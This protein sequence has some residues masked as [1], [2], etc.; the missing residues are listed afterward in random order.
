MKPIVGA[1]LLLGI[2]GF[3]HADGPV[4]L[5]P[6]ARAMLDPIRNEALRPTELVALLRLVSNATVAD[7][8]A[9]PGF[10]T[11]PLARAVPRGQ[12]IAADIRDDYLAIV[13]ARAAEAGLRNVRTQRIPTDRPGLAPRSID[14]AFLCQVDHYLRDRASYFAALVPALKPGGRIVLVNYE[15]YRAPDRAAARAVGL[16]VVDEWTPSPPFFMMVL[17]PEQK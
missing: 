15:R 4:A 9:G 16:R 2:T 12:V 5:D 3:C 10:F 11:L 14:V 17:T 8:G 6:Q 1:A 13:S 7:V